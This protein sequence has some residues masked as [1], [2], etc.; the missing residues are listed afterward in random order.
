MCG[1]LSLLTVLFIMCYFI[2]KSRN[3]VVDTE[4][5]RDSNGDYFDDLCEDNCLKYGAV[6]HQ[7]FCRCESPKSLFLRSENRCISE[8]KFLSKYIDCEFGSKLLYIN[9]LCKFFCL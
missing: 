6:V 4:I 2:K 9:N 3:V 8:N 5:I 7:G 1:N